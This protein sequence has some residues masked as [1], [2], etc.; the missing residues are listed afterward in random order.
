MTRCD[1]EAI[2]VDY[3]IQAA[4]LNGFDPQVS[5]LTSC[6]SVQ[7]RFVEVKD[8]TAK[9]VELMTAV[10]QKAIKHLAVHSPLLNSNLC[11]GREP[12]FSGRLIS[13]KRRVGLVRLHTNL[14]KS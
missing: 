5:W 12:E 4:R 9:V 10:E 7:T 6:Q 2:R 1:D 3:R 13:G 14:R 8:F 11:V